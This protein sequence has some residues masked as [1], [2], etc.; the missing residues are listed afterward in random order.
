MAEEVRAQQHLT[1]AAFEGA[2]VQARRPPR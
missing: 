1:V 2:Q